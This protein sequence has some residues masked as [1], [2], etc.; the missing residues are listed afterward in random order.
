M[1]VRRGM[2]VVV[3]IAEMEKMAALH[4][5]QPMLA[6]MGSEAV[7]SSALRSDGAL[8]LQAGSCGLTCQR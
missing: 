6:A 7:S 1:V 2:K 5:L 3:G 8:L 4:C